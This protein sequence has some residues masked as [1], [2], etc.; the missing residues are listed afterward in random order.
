MRTKIIA[1]L[2]TILTALGGLNLYQSI[3]DRLAFD[4][5]EAAVRMTSTAEPAQRTRF[6]YAA[7]AETGEVM[8]DRTFPVRA[9]GDLL[10]DIVHSD[11]WIHTTADKEARVVVRLDGRNMAKAKEWFED[12][13]FRVSQDGNTVRVEADHRDRNWNWNRTGGASVEV[14]VWIPEEFNLDVETSH[15]DVEVGSLRG[16]MELTTSH[17]EVELKQV[18]GDMVRVRSSHGSIE[19][20]DVVSKDVQLVT[21]HASIELRRV[22]TARFVA[23][24]SHS[25]VE[26]DWLEG[27]AEIETSHG[28]IELTL[29]ANSDADLRTSHGDIVLETVEDMDAELDLTG[30]KVRVSSEYALSGTVRD[31][32]VNGRVGSGSARIEAHTSH[33]TVTIRPGRK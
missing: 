21:S 10:V 9:G 19:A 14:E 6:V 28:S 2:L 25:D 30:Q 27:D 24:T 26:I 5:E 20:T 7:T 12:L 32:R 11:L 29:A 8:I 13:D 4:G 22:A 31:D 15:G 33:G 18:D 1:G 3:K 23:A 16:T 17:G